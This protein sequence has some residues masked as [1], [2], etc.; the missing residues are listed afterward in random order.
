[1]MFLIPTEWY[2]YIYVFDYIFVSLYISN[3]NQVIN[4]LYE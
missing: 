3:N 1:M 2:I 4:K